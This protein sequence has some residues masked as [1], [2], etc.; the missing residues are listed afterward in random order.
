[1]PVGA[2]KYNLNAEKWTE[3]NAQEMFDKA[4]Q[5]SELDEYDF[6]G[7]VFKDAGS[8]RFQAEYLIKKFP[9]F[10]HHKTFI[11]ANCESNCFANGKKSKINPTMALGNLNSN[12][13]WAQRTENIN[14]NKSISVKVGDE[15][16]PEDIPDSIDDD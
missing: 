9:K 14:T 11:K 13:G 7:T 2:P 12:H 6:I 15:P 10:A 5:L 16:M 4:L 1:M 8:N 3:E